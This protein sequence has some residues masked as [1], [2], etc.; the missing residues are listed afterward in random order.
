MV[1]SH[2]E[3]SIKHVVQHMQQLGI[4]PSSM[5]ARLC[6][7]PARARVH[8]SIAPPAFPPLC[9][10]ARDD[11]GPGVSFGQLL[12]M[13]DHLTFGLG[14]HGYRAFKY[15]PYGPVQEVLPYLIR[16]AQENSDAMGGVAKELSMR[17]AE[18]ARR[19]GLSK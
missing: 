16:R 8:V 4:P 12:G 7:V 18:L 17:R 9:A 6:R 14:A 13:C 5:C 3:N 11:A 2:N 19:L 1:A 10:V 15:V